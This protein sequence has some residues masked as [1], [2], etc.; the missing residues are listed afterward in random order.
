M[1]QKIYFGAI[2]A[3]VASMVCV[4]CNTNPPEE[5]VVIKEITRESALE[6]LLEYFPYTANAAYTFENSQTGE[7]WCM[8]PF[9]QGTS[10]HKFPDVMSISSM[11]EESEQWENR[12]NAEFNADNLDNTYRSIQTCYVCTAHDY[13]EVHWQCKIRMG[14]DE[15][16]G[17]S[18]NDMRCD[19]LTFWKIHSDTLTLPI[20][21]KYDKTNWGTKFDVDGA[22]ISLVKGIG[23]YDFSLDGQSIWRRV[24]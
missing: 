15:G 13:F 24:K 23:L 2:C 19:S 21:T 18:L 4:S 10:S 3:I 14:L 11:E 1:R 7:K 20:T 17:A 12:I 6:A 16:Y 8:R 22:Y 9:T 5:P